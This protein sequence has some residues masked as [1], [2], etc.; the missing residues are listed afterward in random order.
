[1]VDFINADAGLVSQKNNRLAKADDAY[2]HRFPEFVNSTSYDV[3]YPPGGIDWL[4]QPST[5]VTTNS[6]FRNV[7]NRHIHWIDLAMAF[8]FTG[9]PKYATELKT[10][11]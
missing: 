6:D 1:I 10:Q 5:T 9:D 3:Q 4:T 8:R 2:A 11:L 7:M